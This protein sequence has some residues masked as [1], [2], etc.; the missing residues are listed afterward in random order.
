[1]LAILFIGNLISLLFNKQYKFKQNLI[2]SFVV[3]IPLI[4]IIYE[5]I[6]KL[7]ANGNLYYGGH[8]SFYSD[9]LI[10]LTKYTF[11]NS[12][13]SS[14]IVYSLNFFIVVYLISILLSFYFQ[15]Q[16]LNIRNVLLGIT[17]FCIISV[18]AQHV[19]LGTLY[20]IDRTALFFYPLFILSFCFSLDAFYER[21]YSKK[22]V[23]IVTFLLG[24]NFVNTANFYKTAIWYFDAHSI[25]ILEELNEKGKRE[26]KK[27]KIDFSWPF[28]SSF[29]YYSD[30]IKY[31]F[32]DIV[33]NE[34]DREDLNTTADFYIY[35]NQS[36]EKVGYDASNQKINS[37]TKDT[38]KY[39]KNENIFIFNNL[40]K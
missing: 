26:N 27:I 14:I 17:L 15:H 18:V 12:N 9:T 33:K 20:L 36:L 22:I 24:I 6:R 25:S 8:T 3:S 16:V 29:N 19:L 35:L 28:Q 32:I 2:L 4:L 1:L 40:K 34:Q 23:L 39:Y 30:N 7:K 13:V 11:Y 37:L 38:F 5:P 10:S 31:P 21:W